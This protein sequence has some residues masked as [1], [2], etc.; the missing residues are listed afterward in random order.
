MASSRLRGA[1]I[2]CW[3]GPEGIQW[4]GSRKLGYGPG[5]VAS[6][7]LK[8]QS[9]NSGGVDCDCDCDCDGQWATATASARV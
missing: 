1:A 2:G 3:P 6:S 9:Q 7:S 8:K 4:R 5:W